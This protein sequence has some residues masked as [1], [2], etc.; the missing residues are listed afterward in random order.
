MSK[1]V[2][3][4]RSQVIESVRGWIASGRI[5]PGTRLPAEQGIADELR[6]A[7]GTVRSALQELTRLGVVVA[8]ARRG[9]RAA[10]ADEAAGVGQG[11]V[12]LVSYL[13]DAL[14]SNTGVDAGFEVG[15]FRAA[16]LA[17]HAVLALGATR[18]RTNLDAI[19]GQ[20]R[21]LGAVIDHETANGAHGPA[22]VAALTGRGIPCVVHGDGEALAGCD[23]VVSDSA[24]GASLLVRGLAA[25]GRRRIL[26]VWSTPTRPYWL[27]E[28]EAG[29]AA[30]LAESGLEALPAVIM[31]ALEE[32]AIGDR[33]VL[34]LRMR[35]YLGFLVEP[36]A[37]PQPI[38]AIL[39]TTDTDVFPLAMACRRLGRE[40]GRDVLIAGYDGYWRS[41]WEREVEPY[42]PWASIDRDN[43]GL[44]EVAIRLLV[45][46]LA[47]PG[48]APQRR[49][50]APRLI[51]T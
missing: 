25:A 28:R 6:V 35:Q 47:A 40:P 45:E 30:A 18:L 9:Y 44:G 24:A 10:A 7:R 19:L 17:G 51:V 37:G 27:R 46:R 21:P 13:D 41:C 12:L 5:A 20:G 42:E 43:E 48:T 33:E 8:V 29:I 11:A 4:P 31:P 32:R 38:D 2:L 39:A 16:R 34:E 23:R 26:P 36:L 15:T 14:T 22:I 3:S 1:A 50:V 49:A